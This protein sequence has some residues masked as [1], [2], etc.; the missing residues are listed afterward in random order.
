[1]NYSARH[2]YYVAK[3]IKW[4]R[5]KGYDAEKCEFTGSIGGHYTK[6]DIWGADIIFKDASTIGFIQV[7]T[8]EKRIS[9]GR[10][11]LSGIWPASV[12]RI[13]GYWPPRAKEPTL[14]DVDLPKSASCANI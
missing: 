6:K 11:Q 5:D 4:L 8:S 7:K 2:S 3:F 1:M 13:V 14:D 9:E 10:R 12:R